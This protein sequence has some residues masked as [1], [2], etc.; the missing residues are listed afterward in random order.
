[1]PCDH[2]PHFKTSILDRTR[3]P[4][5]G[6][7]SRER[8]QMASGLQYPKNK[9]PSLRPECDVATVPLLA[10]E[11]GTGASVSARLAFLCRRCIGSTK[12]LHDGREMIRRIANHAID[13]VLRKG[14]QHFQA[15]TC[16]E[17]HLAI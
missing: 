9:S 15:V 10:H 13:G 11:T 16:M 8:D 2:V 7:R 14:R 12:P 3:H 4:M 17:R 6:A 1:M 5:I